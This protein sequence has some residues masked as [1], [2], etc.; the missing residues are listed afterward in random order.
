[1]AYTK[2]SLTPANNNAAPPD[3][4]PEGM[5]PSAVNDT[6]RDMMA[7]IRDVGDGIR[8]GTYT[9][10]APIITGGTIT[11]STINNSAIGATTAST[12][13]F[14]T[15]S[16]TGVTTVQAGTVSAPAITTSGDTNTG[17]FFPAADTIAFTEG[18]AES[19]RITDVGNLGI[20]TA[21]PN[22]SSS[23][24]A[25]TV[26]NASGYVTYEIAVA[27]AEVWRISSNGSAGV[28]DVTAGTQPRLFW[29][30]GAERM[31]I[32]SSGNVGIGSSAPNNKLQSAYTVPASVP[33]AGAGAHG[34]AVGSSG[35]GLAGGALSSGNAYI[36]STRWD[37]SATNYDLL[38]QPNGGNVG[39]GTSSPSERLTVSGAISSTSNAA[40]FNQS[41]ATFDYASG[42][43]RIASHISTGS[44]LQFY[45]NPN[46]GT[47]T[48]RM[49]ILAN[50]DVG[51]GTTSPS[52]R[53]GV[54]GAGGASLF[55]DFSAGGNTIY[56][57]TNHIFRSNSGGSERMRI[58]SDGNVGIGTTTMTRNFN[59]GGS[60]PAVGMN[61]NNT[62][63]SGRSYSIM[64][65]NS[66]ASTV[67]SLAFF[68]DT[69]GA[70]RMVI[71]S[72]GNLLVGTTSAAGILTVNQTDA[73]ARTISASSPASY[74]ATMF[75][76]DSV[77][78]A[79]TGWYHL[80]GSSSSS[81]VNNIFIY[82]NGNIQ[83]AN[84]S[85]GAISD[86]KLKENIVDAT[87]K[88]DKLMQ[89]KVRNYN[90]KGEYEQHKQIGVI[91]QELETVFPSLIEETQDRG[92][93]DELLETTTKSV[94]YSVFVPMLIK[95]LQELNAKVD[96]QAAEIAILKGN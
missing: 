55:V 21:T 93:G 23:S 71:D 22:K 69:A 63:T 53:L 76:S 41:K 70:Y 60:N 92:V 38:L 12:G 30:N 47:V 83:N 62:G 84:N 85:Y 44:N 33:S 2:Y 57:A 50:G 24:K 49:R 52:A 6:M 89:V 86:I 11:G 17:I 82:G 64:S 4:A 87:P 42:A 74:A 66:S 95:A 45:T 27:D 10:T 54:V 39:I 7:Q 96:A 80:Y 36:Q 5:L 18:G 15:L 16:A 37:G 77:T 29:T 61:L 51:I 67:G 14:S 75:R 68:D 65:T 73:G 32:D 3:G 19:M 91:A 1:M 78:A 8:G 13:A 35:F 43:G 88:L 40:D 48:E 79:G 34:L 31:R 56:D 81:T 58:A 20:G 26:N 72:S 9:M 90:L 94:K 46:G 28:F 59:V 25:V